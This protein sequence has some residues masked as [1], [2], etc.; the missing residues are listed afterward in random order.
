MLHLTDPLLCIWI[1][2]C[3]V[4]LFVFLF[5]KLCNTSSIQSKTS[6]SHQGDSNQNFNQFPNLF[7]FFTV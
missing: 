5:S 7:Y 2:C 1:D 4:T 3:V 6:G